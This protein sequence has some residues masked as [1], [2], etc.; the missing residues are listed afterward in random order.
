G[1]ELF[2]LVLEGV[3]QAVSG[4]KSDERAED[5]RDDHRDHIRPARYVRD[6]EWLPWLDAAARAAR[7]WEMRPGV[8]L[9]RPLEGPGRPPLAVLFVGETQTWGLRP[10]QFDD[11]IDLVRR[12]DGAA[13]SSERPFLVLGPTSSGTAASLSAMTRRPDRRGSQFRIVSG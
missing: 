5:R 7:C 6:H 13:G 11:A 8:I 4:D 10:A 2:D 9:F 3:E 12:V 1:T